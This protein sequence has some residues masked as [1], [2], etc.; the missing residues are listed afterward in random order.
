MHLACVVVVEEIKQEMSYLYHIL[1]NRI[2]IFIY[3]IWIKE[4]FKRSQNYRLKD[5]LLG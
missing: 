4:H 1:I 5:L 2:L 3:K